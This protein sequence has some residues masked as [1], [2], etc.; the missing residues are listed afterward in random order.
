MGLGIRER[1]GSRA[2]LEAM[3]AAKIDLKDPVNIEALA[4]IAEELAATGKA[5]EGV[6]LADAGLRAHPDVAGFHA[7]RGRA[8]ALSRAPA[9]S[10][11][12]AFE[13]ALEIEPSN[14]RALLGLA[15]LEAAAGASEQALALFDRAI[16]A[17]PESAAP[18]REAAALL[19]AMGRPGDAEARLEALLRDQPY[20]GEAAR[21]LAELR[22]ARGADDQRTQDLA[23]RAVA[24][25]G[26]AEAKALLER[27]TARTPGPGVASPSS[28][29][30]G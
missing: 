24:F 13:R 16:A 6:A 2:A 12:A 21:A 19:V 29:K 25:G 4:A 20:D 8:L 9:A 30:E 26:G 28:D 18:A 15:R 10:A 5:S 7:V 3:R 17:D 22:L 11:R 23:H 14:A 27:A 1:S